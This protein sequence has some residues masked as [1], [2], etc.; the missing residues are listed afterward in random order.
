MQTFQRSSLW[1]L[2]LD[3]YAYVSYI[4]FISSIIYGALIIFP[5]ET[6]FTVLYLLC[7]MS[8]G[9]TLFHYCEQKVCTRDGF[10]WCKLLKRRITEPFFM[11]SSIQQFLPTSERKQN[12]TQASH[13]DQS[14]SPPG[15][16][17]APV[18]KA[19]KLQ[20]FSPK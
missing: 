19:L 18:I 20:F 11:L 13:A 4:R 8:G 10:V 3:L 9:S 7:Y 15:T 5:T 12:K 17:V 16:S 6:V 14:W 1:E 2:T